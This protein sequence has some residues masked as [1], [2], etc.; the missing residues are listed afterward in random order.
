MVQKNKQ[1]ELLLVLVFYGRDF[2]K[3]MGKE[4]EV[5]ERGMGEHR[6]SR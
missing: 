4:S 1:W 2:R 3:L 6:C 5:F